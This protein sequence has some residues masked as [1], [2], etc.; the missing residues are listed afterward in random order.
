MTVR[1]IRIGNSQGVRIPRE[2]VRLYGLQEGSEL[3]LDERR[4][5]ILLRVARNTGTKL[6]WQA[7]YREM[8][9]DAAEIAEWSEWDV[10]AGDGRDS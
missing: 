5:G 1:L 6:P 2:L 7:A 4:E 10:T 8:A 9:G 3:E